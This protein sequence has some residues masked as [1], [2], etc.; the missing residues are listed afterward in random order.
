V[1]ILEHA[2]CSGD[3]HH[4]LRSDPVLVG[5]AALVRY[6]RPTSRTIGEIMHR[7]EARCLL[8][9]T[10]C[11]EPAK[12]CTRA[13]SAPPAA[14]ASIGSADLATDG[15]ASR[16]CLQQ[17][18]PRSQGPAARMPRGAGTGRMQRQAV[19]SSGGGGCI[20]SASQYLSNDG[21]HAVDLWEQQH[22]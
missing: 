15:D 16:V 19:S 3:T 21:W 20:W 9:S 7:V 2:S 5:I 17:L 11:A 4:C 14:A 8:V 1:L 22:V 18:S 10:A 13:T 12:R 6:A